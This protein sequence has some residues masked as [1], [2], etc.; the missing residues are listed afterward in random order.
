[1]QIFGMHRQS[2]IY[3]DK[4]IELYSF[5]TDENPIN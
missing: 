4:R 5:W 3:K 2:T 1:M